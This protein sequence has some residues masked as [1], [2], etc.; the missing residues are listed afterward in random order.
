M[1]FISVQRMI[2]VL[3]AIIPFVAGDP[4]QPLN[5]DLFSVANPSVDLDSL[6]LPSD[7]IASAA[8]SSMFLNAESLSVNVPDSS[9]WNQASNDL[10]SNEPFQLAA[11]SA[12]DD[13][14]VVGKKSRLRLRETPQSCSNPA[15]GVGN[16]AGTPDD[17]NNAEDAAKLLNDLLNSNAAELLLRAAANPTKQNSQCWLYTLGQYP[18][19]VCDSGL[20][21]SAIFDGDTTTEEITSEDTFTINFAT[22]G[23]KKDP[24]SHNWVDADL[25]F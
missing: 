22:L 1:S 21:G 12:L 24:M 4:E 5:D 20:E 19:G 6:F 9:L 25:R 3:S 7:Q 11:C 14:G 16:P 18:V 23:M 15:T 17:S 10:G 8:S 13:F 2:S